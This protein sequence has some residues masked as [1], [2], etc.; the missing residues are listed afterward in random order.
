[1]SGAILKQDVQ[2][3]YA[4]NWGSHRQKG[5]CHRIIQTPPWAVWE[6]PVPL[7]P[8]GHETQKPKKRFRMSGAILK[9]DVQDRAAANRKVHLPKGY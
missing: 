5:F 3:Q 1:M 4:S 2:D 7:R 8:V 9:Q 6:A